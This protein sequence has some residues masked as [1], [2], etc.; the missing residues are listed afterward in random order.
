MN[1]RIYLDNASTTPL[2]EEVKNTMK[3]VMENEF[4]NSS[5]I[6]FHGR[7]ARTI[8]EQSRKT[9]AKLLNASVGEIFFTSSATEANNMVLKSLVS[10]SG[11]KRIIS[12]PTEHHCVLHSLDWI[13]QMNMAEVVY[14]PVN[15]LGQPD[16]SELER[17]LKEHPTPT[18]VS[19]MYGNNEIGT[20]LDIENTIRIC[21][22][23]QALFHCD[24]VQAIGKV[25]LDL[26]KINIDYLSASAHKFH[27]PKGSGFVY[28]RQ[29]N[30]INPFIHGGAQERNMRAGTE[31][32]YGI[33]GMAKALEIAIQNMD[34]HKSHLISLRS[35]FKYKLMQVIPDVQFNGDQGDNSLPHI[36]SV[37]FPPHQ[38]G[39]LLIMNLDIAGISASSGSACASG[40][41]S[42]SHVLQA[43]GHDSR[44]K[45]IRFSFSVYNT[46]EE[47]HEVAEKLAML[48][49]E[50]T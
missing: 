43:I 42:D 23:Y 13:S 17:L 3:N 4:G 30:M 19:L 20:L 2:H 34:N 46:L 29:E 14:L 31:N 6:H 36:L 15:N 9:I 33:A 48:T 7:R 49:Q 35:A 40:V 37:S 24:A 32:T 45:T 47:L 39:D 5:S 10:E 1:K 11:I 25:P 22:L 38:K 16:L 27:G 50:S 44:R 41:E 26:Q 12:S 8:V 28:I 18:L 21:K